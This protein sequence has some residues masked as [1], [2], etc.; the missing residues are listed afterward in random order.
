MS[1]GT[2]GADQGTELGTHTFVP[3]I[4]RGVGTQ[5]GRV[6]GDPTSATRATL[7]VSLA[8]GG[9]P[10]STAAGAIPVP[11]ALYGPGDAQT[12]DARSV[13]RTWPRPDVFE[14]EPNYFPLIELQPA[15]LPW[16]YTPARANASDR[17][18]PWLSLIVLRDDEIA[19]LAQ[20]T[21]TMPVSVLTV[22][23]ATSLPRL[24][25]SWAWAHVQITG[26]TTVDQATALDLLDN[27]PDQ[28]LAR[29]L[30][31]RRLDPTTV[32]TAFLVPALQRAVLA[33]LRQP[34]P[35]AVDD[36]APAWSAG[37]TNI[38]LPVHYRW[39]F[40]TGD[41]GDFA[42]LVRRVVPRPMPPTVGSRPMDESD[43]GLALPPASSTPLNAEGALRALD[44]TST[45]WDTA[46]EAGWRTAVEVLLNRP[47]A[48]LA[49]PG[50]ERAVAPPLYGQWLAAANT[51]DAAANPTA[52]FGDLNVDPR[53]RVGGGLGTL[54]V[55]DHQQQYLAGAWAQVAG[56]R[57]ANAALRAAQ[58]AREAAIQLYARHLL[59]RTDAS[60]VT[61]SAP[62][63]AR[64]L[65]SPRTV[66]AAIG[67]SPLAAGLLTPAWRRLTRPRGPLGLRL[68]RA[69]QLTGTTLVE[70]VN[71][72][73]RLV[74]APPATPAQLATLS[75]VGASLAPS[76]L[77]PST[78]DRIRSM[79][80]LDT[81]QLVFALAVAALLFAIGGGTL[82]I[83][84]AL[85]VVAFQLFGRM[86]VASRPARDLERRVALRSGTLTAA[87]VTGAPRRPQ[88]A[89]TEL[90][91][92]P[93]SPPALSTGTTETAA[94]TRFRT[95]AAAVFAEWQSPVAAG[96]ALQA[97]DLSTIRSK[98]VAALDPRTTIAATFRQRLAL[99]AGL[100]W[101]YP[102]PLEPVMA[103]PMF[104]DPMYWP[105]Y[106]VSQDWM[107]PGLD[108][109]PQDTVSLVRTNQRF[110]ESY[111]VGLNHEMARTLLFNEY[112]TDQRGTY[113]QRFWD[114][115][116]SATPAVDITPV[117]GWSAPSALGAHSG[118]PAP[119]GGGDYLVLLLRAELLRRYPN[120]VVYATRAKWNAVGGREVDDSLE[121]QPAFQGRL[122]SGVGFWGFDLT[123]TQ[124]RGGPR[125]GDDPGWFFMLQEAPTEPR[126]GLEPA[127]T[128]GVKP[129]DW[130]DL[131]WADLATNPS[132]LG[133]VT[134]IDLTAALPDTS[135]V[136]D[137]NHAVWQAGAGARASDLAYITYRVPVRVAVH[138][139][140][141]IPSDVVGP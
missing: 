39:R 92:I 44:S 118:R 136:V 70:R 34:V 6:D 60:V 7:A 27:H 2:G 129:T 26:E 126:C 37:D 9:G 104:S 79:S 49:A 75:R 80:H 119:T 41:S 46:E 56:I 47:A 45:S 121:Q 113:F 71:S 11:L 29:L 35:D 96:P 124:V 1:I 140:T 131:S 107:L 84:L 85:A 86:I 122:G 138:G 117:A 99:G 135:A 10:L 120:I 8:I 98:I 90:T 103:A 25:Q 123:V 61:L 110:V 23:A 89:P 58:L 66:A 68:A 93:S 62:V 88:F 139:S 48:L 132:T 67:A 3:W 32:Y 74:A 38:Q 14:A 51:V 73:A 97:V 83:A 102:D 50:G 106:Q 100:Q 36:M 65:T 125:P 137:P 59:V 17:L 64:I 87:Q 57:A 15:D 115:N 94:A 76:W 54:V 20:P 72:G 105:L 24:D 28:I 82:G 40:Q 63:H 116:G 16:R 101:D 18:R 22:T 30:C 112:P 127:E 4:R 78:L 33:G 109:V 19:A 43:P 91:G 130:P 134:H 52:W 31:P 5:I 42:S 12:V 128:F 114:S 13:I 69:G 21:P 111:M 133:A 53:M 108:Q 81:Q 95:A 55:Q 77:T 141:M